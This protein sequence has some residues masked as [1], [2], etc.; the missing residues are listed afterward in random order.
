MI[1]FLFSSK[2]LKKLTTMARFQYIKGRSSANIV[3]EEIKIL[4]DLRDKLMN[5]TLMKKQLE[6]EFFTLTGK[7]FSTKVLISWI[8]RINEW[9]NRKV[10]YRIRVRVYKV[11]RFLLLRKTV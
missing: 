9:E 7:R 6:D 2:S 10:S 1:N 5:G 11:L 3:E 8:E 4:E